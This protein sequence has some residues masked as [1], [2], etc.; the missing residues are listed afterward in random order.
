MALE[1]LAQVIKIEGASFRRPWNQSVFQAEL[2]AP[3]AFLYVLKRSGPARQ[4]IIAYAAFR[5]LFDQLHIMR[6]AVHTDWR[7]HGA[8]T[9][10]LRRAL[11]ALKYLPIETCTLEVQA[12]NT[13]A[14]RLYR[15]LGFYEIGKRTHY[16]PE[17]GEDALI[18]EKGIK[19][20]P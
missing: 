15:S 10:L 11:G 2:G 3:E 19:E 6:V 18:L 17:T 1:D 12:G 5:I 13:P 20:E 7:R 8:A 9:D 14:I 16:Y 4:P